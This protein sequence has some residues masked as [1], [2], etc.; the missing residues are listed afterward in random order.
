MILNVTQ[1]RPFCSSATA[2]QPC[3]VPYRQDA[4]QITPK[5]SNPQ[6]EEKRR[7]EKRMRRLPPKISTQDHHGPNANAKIDPNATCNAHKCNTNLVAAGMN[8]QSECGNG[9][10]GNSLLT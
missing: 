1:E 2:K 10:L 4:T 5:K 9:D 8:W 6:R 7:E 3:Q